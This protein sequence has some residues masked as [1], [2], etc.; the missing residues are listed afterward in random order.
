MT[1]SLWLNFPVLLLSALI[2]TGLLLKYWRQVKDQQ[3]ILGFLFFAVTM[4]LFAQY[5]GITGLHLYTG[6]FVIWPVMVLLLE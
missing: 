5:W 2:G 1:S 6:G 3:I 4:G